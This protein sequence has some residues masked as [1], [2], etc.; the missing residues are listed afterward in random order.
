MEKDNGNISIKLFRRPYIECI[1]SSGILTNDISS[2]V[3]IRSKGMGHYIIVLFDLIILY[4]L[5]IS[6]CC[7]DDEINIEI[8]TTFAF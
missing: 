3:R 5:I 4:F 6:R 2:L 8:L 1:I 7:E